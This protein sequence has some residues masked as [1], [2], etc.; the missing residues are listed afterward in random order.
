VRHVGRNPGV[1]L[2]THVG[3]DGALARCLLLQAGSAEPERHV[4]HP[5]KEVRRDRPRTGDSHPCHPPHRRRPHQ[6]RPPARRSDC[7]RAVAR[8]SPGGGR[9][10]APGR[11]DRPSRR[12]GRRGQRPALPPQRTPSAYVTRFEWIGPGLPAT[13]G[14]LVLAYAPTASGEVWTHAALV[15][16]SSIE[17]ASALTCH[18]FE[19]MATAFLANLARA[20]ELRSHAA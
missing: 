2:L 13:T 18:D 11:R 6:H 17:Q 16:V 8:C 20:A 7:L 12:P 15:L 3:L 14:E 10:W 5:S 19:A 9:Q 4:P 1:G